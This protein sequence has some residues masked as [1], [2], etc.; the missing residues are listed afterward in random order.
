[1]PIT[2]LI[3]GAFC[4]SVDIPYE[5]QPREA[6]QFSQ[7][8]HHRDERCK[9]LQLAVI[10][11]VY[12]VDAPPRHGVENEEDELYDD[13]GHSDSNSGM[14]HPPPDDCNDGKNDEPA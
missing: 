3:Y 13:L 5:Q 7:E 6:I 10:V 1:M 9:S 2:S 14:G 11:V 4:V 8:R 12:N